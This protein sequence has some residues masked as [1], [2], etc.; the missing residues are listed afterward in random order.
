MAVF[1]PLVMLPTGP[2]CMTLLG[3][4]NCPDCQEPMPEGACA[5]CDGPAL[6]ADAQ[7]AQAWSPDPANPLDFKSTMA[8]TPKAPSGAAEAKSA[9]WR[10]WVLALVV[11]SGLG[12]SAYLLLP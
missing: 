11:A 7:A 1:V 5:A 2:P 9:P 10:R 3:M 6:S 4:M 12:V 8:V